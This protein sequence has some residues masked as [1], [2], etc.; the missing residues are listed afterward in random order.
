MS[1]AR[2]VGAISIV[3]IVELV[4]VDGVEDSRC[5]TLWCGHEYVLPRKGLCTCGW[6]ALIQRQQVYTLHTLLV[7]SPLA[8]LVPLHFCVPWRVQVP[9]TLPPLPQQSHQVPRLVTSTMSLRR[10]RW[11]NHWSAPINFQHFGRSQE[12]RGSAQGLG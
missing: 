10:P 7:P 8:Y 6:T 9:C 5:M 1:A 4:R 2:V 3:S 11:A 12:G